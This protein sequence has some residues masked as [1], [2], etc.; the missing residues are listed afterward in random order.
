MIIFQD[1]LA[2]IG[3]VT[4]NGTGDKAKC[5]AELKELFDEAKCKSV[6]K[7]NCFD[8][9]DDPSFR[10]RK[11]Y[12]FSTFWYLADYL[13]LDIRVKSHLLKQ[14][15]HRVLQQKVD[16]LCGRRLP[17]PPKDETDQN[18][19]FRS[20]LMTTLLRDG[21]GF[22]EETKIAVVD[23]VKGQAVGWSLGFILNKSKEFAIAEAKTDLDQDQ[24]QGYS[25]YTIFYKIGAFLA[26]N[27]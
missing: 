18:E 3:N 1:I 19:C 2:N 15:H 8:K 5:E 7:T 27:W 14:E 22:G 25:P 23:K 4:F 24:E 17:R 13:R 21:Y 6:F 10:P 16:G 26:N 12:A 11:F 9:A 20:V